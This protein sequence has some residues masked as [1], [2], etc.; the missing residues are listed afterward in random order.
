MLKPPCPACKNPAP[1]F[2]EAASEDALVDYY[3]CDE[4]S[5]VFNVP[6]GRPAAEPVSVMG[7]VPEDQTS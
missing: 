4:C 1:R 6:K 7:C 5:C 3:R 2:L